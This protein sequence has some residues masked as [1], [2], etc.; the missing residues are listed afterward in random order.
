MTA[1]GLLDNVTVDG[2]VLGQPVNIEGYGIMYNKAILDQAGISQDQ[3]DACDTLTELN[4]LFETVDSQKDAL[5]LE[6]TMG[7]SVG[8][9][10]WWVAAY[11]T[12][13]VPFAMQ[14]DPMAF[15]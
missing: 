7:W 3:I 11:H 10:A 6:A 5:G 1:E 8:G 15:I 13:N 12:F 2:K 4:A 14:E 9:T